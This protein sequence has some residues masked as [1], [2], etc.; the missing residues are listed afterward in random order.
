MYD[1]FSFRVSGSVLD[2]CTWQELLCIITMNFYLAKPTD[3]Q[4]QTSQ[5]RLLLEAY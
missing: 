4:I 5:T 2:Y 3:L 1:S